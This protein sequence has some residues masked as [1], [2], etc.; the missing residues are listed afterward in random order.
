MDIINGFLDG[1]SVKRG[2][3]GLY[4]EERSLVICRISRSESQDRNRK[5]YESV[6]ENYSPENTRTTRPD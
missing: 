6:N 2:P 5:D 1:S 3:V 4:A